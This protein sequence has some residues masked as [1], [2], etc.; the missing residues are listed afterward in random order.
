MANLSK[1]SEELKTW[2]IR[3]N[4]TQKEVADRMGISRSVL[5]FLEN[6]QQAPKMNHIINLKEKWGLDLGWTIT[7]EDNSQVQ[8]MAPIHYG[9]PPE[10]IKE[11]SA[12]Y[13]MINAAKEVRKDLALMLKMLNGIDQEIKTLSEGAQKTILHIKNMIIKDQ[14]VL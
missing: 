6:G 4:L 13:E 3:R 10:Q 5:S 12:I 9:P 11:I 7:G 8:E 1:F 14:M 2:R